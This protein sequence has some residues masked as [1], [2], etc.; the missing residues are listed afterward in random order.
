M[1]EDKTRWDKVKSIAYNVFVVIGLAAS[2]HLF[3]MWGMLWQMAAVFVGLCGVICLARVAM[4]IE[5]LAKAV[6][7]RGPMTSRQE[8]Q[9]RLSRW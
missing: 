1:S 2:I 3:Y 8:M 5:M 9:R 4:A 7:G 6:D